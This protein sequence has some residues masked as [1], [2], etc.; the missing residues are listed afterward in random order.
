MK[1]IAIVIAAS[2]IFGFLLAISRQ[3][4]TRP[5]LIQIGKTDLRV[6]LA[7]TSA[8]RSQGLSGRPVLPE[9]EGMLFVFDEPGLYEFWMKE[10]K[11]PLDIVWIDEQ[12]KVVD[13]TSYVSQASFPERF[14]SRVPARYVLEANAG[15]AAEHGVKLGTAIELPRE[16]T[17][18]GQK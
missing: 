4:K 8:E 5:V 1:R 15:W 16:A 13:I 11:F 3:E 9:N 2:V 18:S 6:E 7:R 17:R 10:M 12:K 14:T